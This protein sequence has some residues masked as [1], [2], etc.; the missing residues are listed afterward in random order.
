M[1]AANING[2]LSRKQ[3]NY[4][5]FKLDQ[6]YVGLIACWLGSLLASF[7]IGFVLDTQINESTTLMIPGPW[8]Y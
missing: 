5:V 1:K 8:Y 6:Q 4:R 7:F 2:L 3:K